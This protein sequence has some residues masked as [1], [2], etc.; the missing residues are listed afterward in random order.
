METNKLIFKRLIR[1]YEFILEDL[2]DLKNIKE[3]VDNEFMEHLS[4]IDTENVLEGG[5]VAD[6]AESWSKSKKDI[7]ELEAAEQDDRDPVFKKIFR[8]IVVKCHPDKLI[9][10]T[11]KEVLYYTNIYN[12]VIEANEDQDWGLL[13]RTAIKLEIEIPE[14]A[15]SKVEEIQE[16]LN[17]LK[18]KQEAILNSASWNWYHTKDS[19]GQEELLQNHL[20]FLK[21]FNKGL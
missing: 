15:Y 21:N 11:E 19:N 12:D 10:P 13:I 4:E 5:G 14:E 18:A 1:E 7:K 17:K 6:A 8:K 3:K 16:D 20:N 2:K 9:E